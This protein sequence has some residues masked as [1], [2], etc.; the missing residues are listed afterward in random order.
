MKVQLEPGKI[1]QLFDRLIIYR[2]LKEDP[3]ISQL[4]RIITAEPFNPPLS[5][6]LGSILECYPKS[7]NAWAS[8]LWELIENDANYF[9]L[10]CERGEYQKIPA[11]IIYAVQHDLK[12]LGALLHWEP[13][14]GFPIH[15]VPG[16]E[17]NLNPGF[18]S[19]YSS[20]I[21]AC[22][23]WLAEFYQK[24]GAG[25][26]GKYHSFIWNSTER[27]FKPVTNPD[28]ITFD[29]LIGYEHQKK[30]LIRNTLQFLN[31]LPANNILLYGDRGTGKSSS[32][33]ALTNHFSKEK[34]RLIEV[35]KED[36][37]DFATIVAALRDR[38][39]KFI[40]FVDDLSFEDEEV[41]YKHL[42]A[43][44]EGG[45]QTKPSNTLIYATSNRR[46]LVAETFAD[47]EE[48]IHGNDVIQEKLSLSDRF[49]VTLTYSTPTREEYLTIVKELSAQ[50]GI[51]LPPSEIE[52]RAIQ[53]ENYQNGRSGRTA[54]QFVDQLAG[55]LGLANLKPG[56]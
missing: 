30:T 23:Q 11:N 7:L 10:R 35:N 46:H 40:L 14:S 25:I 31:G 45:L 49:G 56:V 6:W 44:L 19:L 38:G 50:R 51:K 34:L 21:D 1:V 8:F 15:I 16:Q 2:S 18:D 33:K 22:L 3:L 36:L 55:E 52:A 41:K 4:I 37:S 48:E 32:I 20:K 39:L 29:H 24:R 5:G 42:K 17:V 27:S 9:A 12:I 47:R 28:Q 26:F 13:F 53:W 43:V 54:K